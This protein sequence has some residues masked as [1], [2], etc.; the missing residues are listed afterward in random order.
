MPNPAAP[1]PAGSPFDPARQNEP[2]DLD[3]KIV[4]ALERLAGVFRYL[5]WQEAAPLGLSPLQLQLVVFLRFH[6]PGQSTVSYLAR[7]CGVSRGTVSD[8]VK[9]LEQKGFVSRHAEPVDLRSHHLRLTPA[10][11]QLAERAG[12]FAAPLQGPVSSLPVRQRQGLYGSLLTVL[13]QLQRAGVIPL[14]RLC[15]SCRH[16]AQLPGRQPAGGHFCHLLN[17]PLEGPQ[18]RIDCPEHAV[19]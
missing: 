2:P 19:A 10:G 3:A 11:A 6:P 16:Y 18:L 5:Q 13:H 8:A 9:S 1:A 15:F 12:Q 7:E 17:L 14:Q 4:V